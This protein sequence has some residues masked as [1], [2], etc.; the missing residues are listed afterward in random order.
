VN[1]GIIIAVEPAERENG[2]C[3]KCGTEKLRMLQEDLQSA[4]LHID[5]LK[6]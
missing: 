5:E 3:D 2:N 4:L 1:C 6:A